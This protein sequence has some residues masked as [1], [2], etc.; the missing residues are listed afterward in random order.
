MEEE[1]ST[2]VMPSSAVASDSPRRLIIGAVAG[3]VVSVAVVAA[4]WVNNG[5]SEP[6]ETVTNFL[7]AVPV[8][9]AWT[10]GLPQAASYVFLLCYG[11]LIGGIFGRLISQRTLRSRLAALLF[12]IFLLVAHSTAQLKLARDIEQVLRALVKALLGW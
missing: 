9:L 3:L 8:L 7:A 1:G 2:E 11:A 10:A 5:R 12:M 6:L 4:A